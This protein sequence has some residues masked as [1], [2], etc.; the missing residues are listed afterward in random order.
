M[1]GD[2]RPW[3]RD[4]LINVAETVGG[5]LLAAPFE[6][7][8]KKAQIIE[9]LTVGSEN[10]E[11]AVWAMVH[12]K[13]LIVPVKFSKEAVMECNRN[14]VSGRRLTETKTALVTLKQFRPFSTRI[15]FRNGGMTPEAH[16]ALHCESVSIVGSLGESRWGN[17]VELDSDPDLREWS[18]ALRQHGG[19]GNILKERKKKR[20]GENRS[21]S[22]LEPSKR[23]ASPPK[24]PFNIKP[25]AKASTSK[26]PLHEWRKRWHAEIE[27]PLD[28]VRPVTPPRPSTPRRPPPPEDARD[29][30]SSSPAEKYCVTSS[31][32]DKC[33]RSSSPIS[34][35]SPTTVGSSPQR[36][37]ED[38]RSPTPEES[39]KKATASPCPE[40]E[41]SY[42]T[43]PTPAQRRHPSPVPSPSLGKD[44]SPP[45]GR[46][47][48]PD[49]DSESSQP[50]A[51][52][53]VIS[54][55]PPAP[56]DEEML[57]EDD[58]TTERRLFRRP[59][60][61]LERERPAKKKRMTRKLDGFRVD[62][63]YIEPKDEWQAV[64]W[65][66]ILAVLKGAMA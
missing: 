36:I 11:S 13:A 4:H 64:G 53:P 30:G 45:T 1:S 37:H 33:S 31:P 54:P 46:V 28:F 26:D 25:V 21:I 57:S 60:S 15:P 32:S 3:I 55:E 5:N 16:L 29:L 14:S 40:K 20:E 52:L 48:V 12:D 58:E 65:D 49:S 39:P 7:K 23:V 43:A 17:P 62:F 22:A 50:V 41:S 8:G 66:R 63:D 2:L 59:G 6:K 38:F 56:I 19:A 24:P 9:F 44:V 51:Q 34:G 10:Q 61:P 18:H 27:N 42:L 47:L 35:W